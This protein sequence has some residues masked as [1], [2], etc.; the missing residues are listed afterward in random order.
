[1]TGAMNVRRPAARGFYPSQ[2]DQL[3]DTLRQLLEE[4]EVT[5]NWEERIKGLIVPHA[6]YPY[7]GKTAAYAYKALQGEDYSDIVLLGPNHSGRGR[8]FSL[9]LAD[10]ETPLGTVKNN[11]GLSQ[12]ILDQSELI[13]ANEQAH[14][15]EHSIEV[16]LPFLQTVLGEFKITPISFIHRSLELEELREIARAIRRHIIGNKQALVIASS[17]L[18]HYGENYGYMPEDN[19]LSFVE[20]KDRDFIELLKGKKFEKV[21]E[22]GRE[23]TICGY[24]PI[25]VLLYLLKDENVELLDHSTSYDVT[26]DANNIVGYGSLAFY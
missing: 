16:Q 22:M 6:G 14:R 5:G 11:T 1:L 13:E 15:R 7:S 19:G 20:N 26:G 2:P 17:D 8:R 24:A 9:S 4:A 10:W 3:E 23:T 25:T 21:L 18:I 12:K